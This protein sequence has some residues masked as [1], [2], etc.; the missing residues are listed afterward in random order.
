MSNDGRFIDL[1]SRDQVPLLPRSLR[2]EVAGETELLALDETIGELDLREIEAQYSRVGAPGY[3]PK[4]LLA[5]LLYGYSQGYRASRK[6]EAL[7]KYDVRF[8]FLAYGLRPDFHTI[9]R[10]RRNQAEALKQLFRQTVMRCQARGLVSLGRVA[11]DG[12]KVRA[13]RNR[14]ALREAERAFALALEEAETA[15]ADIP[16]ETPAEEGGALRKSAAQAEV[17]RPAR[18]REE[19]AAIPA[20]G[21]A[22]A[23]SS[24]RPTPKE[25][26]CALMKTTEGIKPAFNGQLAVDEA[27]QVIVAQ[28]LIV[29]PNDQGQLAPL[30][31]Q[32]EQ[33][34]GEAPEAVLAD[35]GYLNQE[36]LEQVERQGITPYLPVPEQGLA[37]MEWVEAQGA[38]RCPQGN[39]LR[40][41]QNRNGKQVYRTTRCSGCPQA[42]ACGITGRAK[43]L[44]VLPDSGALRRLVARMKAGGKTIY[45]ARSK[46]VEPVFACFKHNWGF[47]RFLL[48]DRR[49]A[50]AEWSLLCI[51]HNLRKWAA[52][53]RG[54]AAPA[55]AAESGY[56][57]A[58]QRFLPSPSLFILFFHALFALRPQNSRLA[59]QRP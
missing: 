13:N 8:R 47:R 6:L 48:R 55:S 15:D 46:I 22:E 3:E 10:F 4:V 25:Q 19:A 56:F 32:V 33:N 24:E 53:Q 31:L 49:G 37:R 45:R 59:S 9:C 40:P 5:V 44:H 28:D 42:A 34:C 20:E 2:Q 23:A 30:L 51:A 16:A 12:S 36:D 27:N 7:C 18:V 14:E 39:Y 26:A 21:P 38:F 54:P 17:A 11:T 1:P 58:R 50:G 35:G 29:A 43:E 41:Y 57:E 52:A